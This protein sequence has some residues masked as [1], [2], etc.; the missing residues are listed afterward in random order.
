[1]SDTLHKYISDYNITDLQI[2]S[3]GARGADKM[4]EEFAKYYGHQLKI[5]PADWDTYGKA[6][7]YRRNADMA[8]YADGCIVYWNEISKGTGHMIDL[9]KRKDIDLEIVRY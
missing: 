9:A 2:V 1:M 4:G 7:G 6:A 8:D 3:G 5:M